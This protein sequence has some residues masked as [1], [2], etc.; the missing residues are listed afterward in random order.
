MTKSEAILLS[1]SVKAMS[2]ESDRVA[3]STQHPY[4]RSETMDV[5]PKEFVDY[6]VGSM[7]EVLDVV[8][9]ANE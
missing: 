6:F 4:D 9:D 3:F 5:V 2:F 7:I 8:A 1:A